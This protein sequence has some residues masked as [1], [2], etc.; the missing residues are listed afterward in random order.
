[1]GVR[2]SPLAPPLTWGSLPPA[3]RWNG[4]ELVFLLTLAHRSVGRT[5]WQRG[6][7]ADVGFLE[8]LI[9]L[10]QLSQGYRLYTL[11]EPVRWMCDAIVLSV[12][13]TSQY[14]SV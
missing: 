4:P 12:T 7:Q 1:V 13:T 11:E 3:K 9:Q 14:G 10:R 6:R 2:V 5:L 8:A